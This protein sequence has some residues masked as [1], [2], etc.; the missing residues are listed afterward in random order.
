[1]SDKLQGLKCEID[2]QLAGMTW[3]QSQQ[4]PMIFIRSAEILSRFIEEMPVEKFN[5]HLDEIDQAEF[6][7]HNNC[8]QQIINMII[9][10]DE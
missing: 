4:I 1:M 3:E 7:G 9:G 8:R 5:P 6:D 10:D 2:E